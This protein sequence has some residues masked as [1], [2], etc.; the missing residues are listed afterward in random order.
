MIISNEM[1]Y[2]HL[3]SWILKVKSH[4]KLLYEERCLKMAAAAQQKQ[5]MQFRQQ[6][7]AARQEWELALK[8]Q[9]EYTDETLIDF[10]A[11]HIKA[12]ELKFRHLNNLARRENFKTIGDTVANK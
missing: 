9:N 6:L 8:M 11:Y 4:L 1:M 3:L 7:E 2:R 12:S 10:G 5:Q